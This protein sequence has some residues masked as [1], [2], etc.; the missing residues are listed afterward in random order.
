[1]TIVGDEAETK[2][3]RDEADAQET[4][5]KSMKRIFATLYSVND[6]TE[7]VKKEAKFAE[8]NLQFK[9]INVLTDVFLNIRIVIDKD[10][11]ITTEFPSQ[12]TLLA[13]PRVVYIPA[14]RAGM[15]RTYKQLLRLYLESIRLP[16]LLPPF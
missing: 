1:V 10:G 2:I 14:E 15:M 6:L 3:R 7:L 4:V 8:I 11:N 13:M 5:K 16:P 9:V 12:K